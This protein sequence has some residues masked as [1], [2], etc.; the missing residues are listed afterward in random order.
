MLAA[1]TSEMADIVRRRAWNA[2]RQQS[3]KPFSLLRG[4][5][6]SNPSLSSGES[7][8][9]RAAKATFVADRRDFTRLVRYLI[10]LE[11][12]RLED[13]LASVR[14]AI[15]RG[16]IGF[17]AVKHLVLCRIERRRGST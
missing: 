3:R 6:G 13:V 10:R 5:E 4:T 11:V 16:V 14:E 12:F 2:S 17:D 9:N 15:A 7:G 8:T 1:I